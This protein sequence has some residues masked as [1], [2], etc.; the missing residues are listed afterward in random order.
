MAGRERGSVSIEVTILVPVFLLLV[1]LAA[2]AGRGVVAQNAIEVAAHDAARAASISRT[3]AA[4]DANAR[5]AVDESLR[6][7]GL[8]CA[9]LSV[10]TDVTDFARPVGPADPADPPVV[11]VSVTCELSFADLP[12][13]G[14]LDSTV[15]TAA[16]TSP[17][18]WY[19]SRS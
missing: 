16:F 18:D 15:L 4:A 8:D 19:R 13:P 12:L 9:A 2:V 6:N 5:A 14:P 1:A 3:A 17:L 7:Q 10:R 11:S